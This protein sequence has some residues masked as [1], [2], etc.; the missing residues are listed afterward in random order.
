MSLRE[1]SASKE[2]ETNRKKKP[3]RGDDDERTVYT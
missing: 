2:T 1:K 3:Q